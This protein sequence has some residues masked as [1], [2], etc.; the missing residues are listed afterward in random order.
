MAT[1]VQKLIDQL[2]KEHDPNEAIIF[3]YVLAEHTDLDQGTFADVSE[4]L[5]GNDNFAEDTTEVFQSWT[6][7]ARDVLE[8]QEEA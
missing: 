3:Q 5:M 8:D 2:Q 6:T 4:Y 1:T 7:E